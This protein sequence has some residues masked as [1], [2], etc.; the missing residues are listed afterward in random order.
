MFGLMKKVQDGQTSRF[1]QAT[2]TGLLHK[3]GKFDHFRFA[4]FLHRRLVL[5]AIQ[6]IAHG[7]CTRATRGTESTTFMAK[8]AGKIARNVQR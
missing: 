3:V 4:L 6:Q 7:H 8:E 5:I 2:M 1:A